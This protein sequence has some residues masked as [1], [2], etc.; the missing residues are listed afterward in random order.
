MIFYGGNMQKSQKKSDIKLKSTKTYLP[1]LDGL[2][3]LAIIG[4]TLF[5]LIPNVF[6]GGYLGVLLFFVITGFLL[7]YTTAEREHRG[8]FTVPSFYAK[9]VKRLYPELI[10]VVFFSVG[11]IWFL[12][13][14]AVQGIRL[15][16]ASVFLGVNNW[17]QIAQNADYFK[18]IA[19]ASPFTHLW[20]LGIE[21]QYILIW[22]L[23]FWGG[24]Q[25]KKRRG[26]FAAW[27]FVLLLSLVSAVWMSICYQI[28]HNVTRVYYGTDTRAFALLFGA[29]LG[30][31]KY[32][33][34]A[35]RKRRPRPR[36][37]GIKITAAFW[38]IIALVVVSYVFIKGRYAFVYDGGMALYTL[39]FGALLAMTVDSR[40]TF[41]RRLDRS[42]VL[43]WIGSHSYGLFL[44]QYPVIF[45]FNNKGWLDH[46][47]GG[48]LALVLI[49]ALSAWSAWLV[50]F[51]E[52]KKWRQPF[53]KQEL[54]IAAVAVACAAAVVCGLGLYTT[55][56]SKNSRAE[57]Q[58]ALK[59]RLEKNQK[60]I[61]KT[62]DGTPIYPWTD[63][64]KAKANYKGTGNA[65]RA[66]VKNVTIIGDSVTLDAAPDLKAKFNNSV[67]INA[68]QS[69]HIGDELDWVKKQRKHHHLGRTV[70]ISLGTNG[71]LY[72]K[73]VKALLK[74][75]GPNRSVFWVNVYGPELDWTRANND[76]LNQ[77]AA[78]TPNLTIIDWNSTL[79][80]HP[81]WLWED[82]IHPNPDG[83]K[84]YADQ[85]YNAIEQV[86][87]KQ[88]AVDRARRQ[89][90]N[91]K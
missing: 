10:L 78:A 28:T 23:I 81:E 55:L 4:V 15:E 66:S 67:T 22:P 59:S 21:I 50:D 80:A 41:G 49:G 69:R 37:A 17:W 9:R 46:A 8:T 24:K 39:A 60:A 27:C 91:K 18:R 71:E 25:I 1:G 6:A 44:W 72:E 30:L 35:S 73:A 11:V 52:K 86:Q 79:S 40:L 47:A 57:V 34:D 76:Y 75:L 51:V 13:P 68:K 83:S 64:P 62:K 3:A 19:S 89:H 5:H 65:A 32:E 43:K 45:V 77:L 2:R 31:L 53:K 84:A 42:R 70:V 26:F 87:T 88:Q 85:I 33:R 20:F 58:Q 36:R 90:I 7:A 12:V 48:V 54:K 38:G 82:G 14:W 61:S 74:V 63:P 56:T 16:V 29:C